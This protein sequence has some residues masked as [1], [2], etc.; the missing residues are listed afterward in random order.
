VLIEAP[1]VLG[2]EQ[3]REIDAQHGLMLVTHALQ[4]VVDSGQMSAVA[5]EPLAHLLLGALNEAAM[6]VANSKTPKAARAEIG[7]TLDVLLD[8]IVTPR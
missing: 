6:L 2:W 5:V 8:R 3:W 7:N 4:A 1:V